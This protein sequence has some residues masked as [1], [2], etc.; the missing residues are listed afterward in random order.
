VKAQ[1]CPVCNGEGEVFKGTPGTLDRKKATCHGCGGLGFVQVV[2]GNVWKDDPS[3]C[4]PS[5]GSIEVLFREVLIP[6]IMREVR[7]ALI[8]LVP[9]CPFSYAG[10]PYR[11]C[12]QQGTGVPPLV[13]WGSQ[14][15]ANPLPGCTTGQGEKT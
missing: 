3:Y 13:T 4:Q 10:C 5:V 15:I 2:D 12:P 6:G 8:P 1:L 14:G 11:G 9:P 7:G